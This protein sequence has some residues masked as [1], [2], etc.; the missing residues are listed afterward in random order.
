MAGPI[1]PVNE[2]PVTKFPSFPLC[3]QHW[4][5]PEA[6]FS[7]GFLSILVLLLI[8]QPWETNIGLNGSWILHLISAAWQTSAP[9]SLA[10]YTLLSRTRP[11]YIQLTDPELS[12]PLETLTGLRN[13]C[14]IHR[15]PAVHSIPGS[16]DQSPINPLAP[17][18]PWAESW[19]AGL[20]YFLLIS[21]C[22]CWGRT[23]LVDVLKT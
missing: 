3:D 9:P 4:R 13:Q 14:L 11:I 12:T 1:L 10:I 7:P 21:G 6:A 8:I 15:S 23:A 20:I 5:E 17:F 18:P 19:Y 22:V 16:S 2:Y